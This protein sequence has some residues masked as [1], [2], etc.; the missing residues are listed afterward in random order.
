MLVVINSLNN[1]LDEEVRVLAAQSLPVLIAAIRSHPETES[2]VP[3][4]IT[5][6]LVL[7]ALKTY[8]LSLNIEVKPVMV[9]KRLQPLSSILM[10]CDEEEFIPEEEICLSFK[11]LLGVMKKVKLLTMESDGIPTVSK[12]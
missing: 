3:K 11:T 5:K 10:I 8:L 7:V 9:F 1:L 12:D 2:Y 6:R 4:E